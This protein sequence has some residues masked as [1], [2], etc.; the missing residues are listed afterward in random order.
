MKVTAAITRLAIGMAEPEQELDNSEKSLGTKINLC[1]VNRVM[2]HLSF[3]SEKTAG[4]TLN[5]VFKNIET[6]HCGKYFLIEIRISYDNNV[7]QSMGGRRPLS[8]AI[9]SVYSAISVNT[10]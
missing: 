6:K 9:Q 8:M 5:L 4:F 2:L 1:S 3:L 10:V 7:S